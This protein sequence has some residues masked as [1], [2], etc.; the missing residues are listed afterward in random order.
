MAHLSPRRL[1]SLA[2]DATWAKPHYSYAE[3]QQRR[4]KNSGSEGEC[5][6][7]KALRL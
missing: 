3:L 1:E 7:L 4:V 6:A 5:P 2:A